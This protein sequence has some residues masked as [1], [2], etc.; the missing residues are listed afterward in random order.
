[1]QSRDVET[2]TPSEAA[3]AEVAVARPE[4]APP[5]AAQR[6]SVQDALGL[7][8]TLGN[9]AVARLALARAPAK[10]PFEEKRAM[11]EGA[12]KSFYKPDAEFTGPEGDQFVFDPFDRTLTIF[13]PKDGPNKGQAIRMTY[14]EG[15]PEELAKLDAKDLFSS[16]EVLSP[17]RAKALQWLRGEAGT[18]QEDEAGRKERLRKVHEKGEAAR[19][20]WVKGS[21]ANQAALDK[22]KADLTEYNQGVQDWTDKKRPLLPAQVKAPAGMPTDARVTSCNLHTGEFGTAV[23]GLSVGGM[24]P[25]QDAINAN[26][27]GAFRTLESHPSGPKAG[28]IMSYGPVFKASKAGGLRRTNFIETKHVGVFKSRRPGPSGTE[29][30]TV[31]DGGQGSFEG[32]Q[33][34][35][36]RTR[37]FARERMLVQIPKRTDS[38]KFAGF[39]TD[40]VEM[41]VGVMKSKYADAGQSDEDKVLRGWIDIDDYFGGTSAATPQGA[42]SRV[43]PGKPEP[44]PVS[45]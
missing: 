25:R 32:R 10:D 5:A 7:Q 43:F 31:V 37:V 42:G 24:D 20:E 1:M 40:M 23:L 41:E 16:T 45:T 13:T 18:Y 17:L 22:Y 34:T 28:D 11:R 39:E 26:R 4:L 27:G 3:A 30:W 38:G 9:R 29:I 33:E 6:L 21:S 2:S 35:R 36:E 15:T 12:E 19:A 14:V 44:V 8:R